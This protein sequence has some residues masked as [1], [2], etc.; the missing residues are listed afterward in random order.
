MSSMEIKILG[1]SFLIKPSEDK[2]DFYRDVASYLNSIM[3][4][5]VK[6]SNVNSDIKIAVKVAFRLAAENME[7]R[8][9]KNKILEIIKRID[10]NIDII[11]DW[12]YTPAVFVYCITDWSQHFFL[13]VA[14]C[15]CGV[16]ALLE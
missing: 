1:Q 15:S 6:K 13:N 12:K 10:N 11:E 8:A 7:L 9:E 14:I 16:Q 2:K 3:N 4:D 5:E